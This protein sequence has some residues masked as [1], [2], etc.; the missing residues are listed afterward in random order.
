MPLSP[1]KTN[2]AQRIFAYTTKRDRF[3]ISVAVIGA[4]GAGLTYPAQTIVFGNMIGELTSS[5][6]AGQTADEVTAYMTHVIHQSV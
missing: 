2:S 3:F 4:I 6:Y 5:N 1:Q